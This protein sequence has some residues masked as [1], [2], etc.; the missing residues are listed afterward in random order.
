MTDEKIIKSAKRES[1]L[2]SIA[3]R[4]LHAENNHT[5]NK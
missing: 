5:T 1:Y 3:K 2:V 4:C